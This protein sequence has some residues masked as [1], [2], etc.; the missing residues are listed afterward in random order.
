M[1]FAG[2]LTTIGTHCTTAGNALSPKLTDIGCGEPEVPV[3]RC[4]RYWYN[5]DGP[6]ARLGAQRTLGD[7]MVGERL[8]IRAYWPV[9]ERDKRV[10]AAL[11]A[12]VQAFVR[13]IKHALIGDSQL[14]GNCTD[15]E[16]GDAEAGWLL[17]EGA[18]WRIVTIP[19][20]LDF[21]DVDPIGA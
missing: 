12:D 11:D 14:G 1:T 4:I 13:A 16:A 17:L 2:A 3:G 6:P 10:L 15:L 18:T 5:G 20:V 19:L 21:V 9:A 8:S 7:Q